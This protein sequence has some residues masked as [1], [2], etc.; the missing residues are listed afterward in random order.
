MFI[1]WMTPLSKCKLASVQE[2]F[3]LFVGRHILLNT[4]NSLL[5]ISSFFSKRYLLMGDLHKSLGTKVV[6]K[7]KQLYSSPY[8]LIAKVKKPLVGSYVKASSTGK[9]KSSFG[10]LVVERLG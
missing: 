2:F 9:D 7:D 8:P 4:I 10:R 6:K 3:K 1:R 5:A